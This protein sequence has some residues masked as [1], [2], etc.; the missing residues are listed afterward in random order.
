MESQS[1]T[2]INQSF[3]VIHRVLTRMFTY[4]SDSM[5]MDSDI[6]SHEAIL[7]LDNDGVTL[8]SFNG[9]TWKLTIDCDY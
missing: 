1:E 3:S 2:Y 5:P 4:L 6:F 7:E 8:L 9:G